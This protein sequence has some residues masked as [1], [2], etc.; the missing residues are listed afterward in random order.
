MF[1][2]S[3]SPILPFVRFCHKISPQTT[4][5]VGIKNQANILDKMLLNC[6]VGKDS[7]ESRG[8]QG[9]PTSPSERKSVLGVHWCS[10]AWCWGWNSKTLA[11]WREELTHL[12]RPSCWE[13]LKV[14]REGNARR[15][16]GWMALP[17]QWTRVWVGSRSW[18][19]TRKPGVLQSMGSQ[20]QTQLSDW[21]ELPPKVGP[22]YALWLSNSACEYILKIILCPCT[23]GDMYQ[24]LKS[25]TIH[26]NT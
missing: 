5:M 19:W 10:S 9:D 18:W 24:N 21:T 4:L 16:D 2:S 3:R 1:N 13:R 6:G 25:S 23:T 26:N 14:G 22:S 20:S 17:V 11:T 15:W 12:K 7:W 8:L